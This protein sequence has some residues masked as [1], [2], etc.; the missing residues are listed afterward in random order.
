MAA[1]LALVRLLRPHQWVKNGLVLA[2]LVFSGRFLE[3]EAVLAALLAVL[4]FSLGASA[5]YVL[6]DLRDLASDR[7][8]PRKRHRPL[9]SGRVSPSMAKGVLV[10][11]WAVVLSSAW[12]WPPVGVVI[13]LYVAM[14]GAYSMGL[15]H[16]PVLDLF[17]VAAGFVLRIFAGAGAIT[18]PVSAW[19]LVTTLTL[20]LYLVTI[21]R[22]Q[23]LLTQGDGARSVLAHYTPG[24]LDHYATVSATATLV[25]YGFFVADVRPELIPTLPF[26]LF[27]VFRFWFIVERRH[28]GESPTDVVWKDPLLLVNVLAW[29]AVSMLAIGGFLPWT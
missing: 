19:M 29:A 6:N 20:A 2:P 23:E 9:P 1:P 4:L 17:I 18:V 13:L 10:A 3:A 7:A 22:R 24:I 8:H 5:V 16:V 11:L 27:G 12:L 25:F 15:K 26:V 28:L 21:K 14:N